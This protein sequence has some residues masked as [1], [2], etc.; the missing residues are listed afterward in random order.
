MQREQVMSR[1]KGF[2]LIELLVVIAI[3][4]ILAA[5]LFPV[6]ARARENARR[7]SCLSNMKQI[8]LGF[9]QYTQDY[10]ERMPASDA[11]NGGDAGHTLSYYVQPYI[12]NTQVF[13]CPSDSSGSAFSYGY[14]YFYLSPSGIAGAIPIAKIQTPAETVALV[15]KLKDPTQLIQ[16]YVYPPQL[17]RINGSTFANHAPV[18]SVAY[19]YGD[20]D[21]RHLDTVNVLWADGHA[22]AQKI[23]SLKGPAGCSGASCDVLWDLN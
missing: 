23:D 4:T 7:A 6:F 11:N 17:W 1:E 18:N 15:D 3:I 9:I 10:D 2:T 14:N 21:P 5:I 8:G 22:K 12:K 20:T 13:Q 16:D 19:N